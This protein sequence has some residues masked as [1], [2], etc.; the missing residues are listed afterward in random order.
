MCSGWKQIKYVSVFPLCAVFVF[1]S[2]AFFILC[3]FCFASFSA[4]CVWVRECWRFCSF[5]NLN[6]WKND[7]ITTRAKKQQ[8]Q[9]VVSKKTVRRSDSSS[10]CSFLDH[11]NQ[12]LLQYVCIR[13]FL[14]R[15]FRHC[16]ILILVN[17]T[18][19]YF[20]NKLKMSVQTKRA[21]ARRETN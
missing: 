4:V 5:L 6:Y 10:C 16:S 7:K 14:F 13:F 15:C 17:R 8:Q 2:G 11:L 18:F 3:I 9:S 20:Q 12:L 1:F 19:G 21:T